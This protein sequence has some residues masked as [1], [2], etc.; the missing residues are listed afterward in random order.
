MESRDDKHLADY[1]QLL[2]GFQND[3]RAFVF[4]ALANYSD[5]ED[6]LQRINVKLWNKAGSFKPN[7]DFGAWAIT[8]AKYE[9]LHYYRSTRRDRHVFDPD[10]MELMLAAAEQRISNSSERVDALRECLKQLPKNSRAL[11]RKRYNEGMTM[12]ELATDTGRSMSSVKSMLLR[13]RRS[14]QSCIRWRLETD[15]S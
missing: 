13:L 4:A 8:V 2:T 6:V 7:S 1:V 10:V 9:L 14:L 15:S 12:K 11:L 3:L 5:S